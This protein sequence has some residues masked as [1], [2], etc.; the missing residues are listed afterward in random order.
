MDTERTSGPGAVRREANPAILIAIVTRRKEPTLAG[1][2]E[3]LAGSDSG[4]GLRHDHGPVRD[5]R[6]LSIGPC[7]HEQ[8]LR[9]GD[10]LCLVLA[11]PHAL[12]EGL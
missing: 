2:D 3:R 9:H 11:V 1:S 7:V 6:G 8:P 10:G 12:H 4:A 5:G